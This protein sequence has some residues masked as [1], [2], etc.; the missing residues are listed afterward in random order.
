MSA[1]GCVSALV[2]TA[3]QYL[4][5]RALGQPVV[6]TAM[7]VQAGLLAQR[8]VLTPLQVISAAC[9]LNIIGDLWWVP[10][11]GAVG[12]A[13]ATLVSQ[14]AALPLMLGLS[15]MRRRL[16]VRLRVPGLAEMRGFIRTA[17]PLFVFEMGIGTCY[18]MI[19][20]LSTQFTV[21]SA[22]AFQALW[23]P[24]SVL[25]FATYPLKQ[26]AQVFLPRILSD[27]ERTVGGQPKAREFLKVLSSLSSACGVGLAAV[28]VGLARRPSLFTADASLWPLISSFA[29]YVGAV[30]LVLGFAQVLE[31]VLL[32]TGDLSFLSQ[33]QLGNVLSAG[34][35]LL[36]TK[37]A[38]MG[39][40]GT[41]L[42]FIVFLLS[43]A[44]QASCRVFLTRRPW[45][46]A[47][48]CPP[49]P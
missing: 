44:A 25:G 8:D 48:Y 20:S 24:V 43:R 2:P 41:W 42:V 35:C 49:P 31:G 39:V 19:Q 10:K 30:L 38:G 12:A 27:E 11:L 15:A 34:A 32:G 5:V 46:E 6:L 13:W 22:A 36:A 7:V 21:A 29:P 45:D 33:S 14:V 4:R 40:H 18:A 9:G 3:A 26:A 37:A 28:G 17:S 23:T 1:T 16:P 47:S